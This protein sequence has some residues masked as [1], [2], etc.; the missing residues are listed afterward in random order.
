MRSGWER[1]WHR[2]QPVRVQR[3]HDASDTRAK[4]GHNAKS[5]ASLTRSNAGFCRSRVESRAAYVL[6]FKE[7]RPDRERNQK[8]KA[9]VLVNRNWCGAANPGRSRLLG[10]SRTFYISG[11]PRTGPLSGVAAGHCQRSARIGYAQIVLERDRR[12]S[13]FCV[14]HSSSDRASDRALWRIAVYDILQPE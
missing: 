1:W 7:L 14:G 5:N 4:R 11:L 12:L 3:E 8:N 10:G 9:P 13:Q 6:V 2:L